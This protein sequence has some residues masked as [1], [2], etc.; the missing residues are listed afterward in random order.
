MY[1][2]TATR[3]RALIVAGALVAATASTLM[4]AGT[5]NA[6][7]RS[8]S[9]DD[10]YNNANTVWFTCSGS[11]SWEGWANCY[12]APGHNTGWITQDGGTVREW[13]TCG[14]PSHVTGLGIHY[15]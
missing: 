3:A 4:A 5:A 6:S 8:L 15:G 2:T 9:C 1:K 14:S 7:A 12:F 11:G 13:L 10:G